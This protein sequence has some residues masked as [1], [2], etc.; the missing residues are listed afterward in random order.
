M[1]L[2]FAKSSGATLLKTGLCSSSSLVASAISWNNATDNKN[3]ITIKVWNLYT[4]YFHNPERLLILVVK[5]VMFCADREF[6]K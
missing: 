5:E 2:F 6:C 1:Q 4:L 3:Y